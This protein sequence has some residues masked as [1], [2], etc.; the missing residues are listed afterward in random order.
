MKLDEGIAD[1][2]L[3]L[4]VTPLIDVVFLLLLFFAVTTSFISPRELDD[5]KGSVV[6]LSQDNSALSEQVAQVSAALTRR[7]EELQALGERHREL[8]AQHL[9]TLQDQREQVAALESRLE[10]ERSGNEKLAW[11]IA[12]LEQDKAGIE[13]TLASA[14][15]DG[16]SLRQQLEQAYED[17][18][19]LNVRY[20]DLQAAHE[21]QASSFAAARDDLAAATQ[22]GTRL[23]ERVVLL[24]TSTAEQR[25]REALLDALIRDKAAE[26]QAISD[27]LAR[28]DAQR[29]RLADELAQQV[30]EQKLLRAL[31]AE[32][33]GEAGALAQRLAASSTQRDELA[34]ELQGLRQLGAEQAQ[35]ARELQ[36]RVAQLEDELAKYR[37]LADLDRE[38]I[39]RIVRAHESLRAGLSEY[40][41]DSQIAIRRDKERLTLQLSDRILFDSGS[42]AIK[43]DGLAVLRRVGEVIQDRLPVLEVQIGGHTDNV[44]IGGARGGLLADNWGLS[45]ARAVSVV[46]FFGEALGLAPDRMSAVGYGEHRPVAANDT[47]EGRARN[48]RIEIVLLPR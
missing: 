10:A 15:E 39:E 41:E 17:F 37:S 2:K 26:A 16:L 25:Q 34:G 3:S 21:R 7:G 48:R 22:H 23:A 8:N 11:M 33:A 9:R 35:L 38:Q 44:P 19:G 43:P 27:R 30:D 6:L 28:G 18:R 42:A 4:D 45:A 36:A 46:H 1:Q 20:T 31:L 13:K 12:A 5:L 14:R 32:K 29:A 40:L 47:A 24:E